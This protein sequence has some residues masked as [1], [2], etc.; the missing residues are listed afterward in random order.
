MVYRVVSLFTGI[1]GLD[2]GFGGRVVVRQESLCTSLVQTAQPPGFVALT[3]LPF[4]VVFQND[5][6]AGAK[7]VLDL[8]QPCAD[9]QVG[10]IYHLLSTNYPFPSADVVI[11]GFPCQDFSHCG[12]R[13]GFQRPTRG[14]LYRAFVEVV[15]RVQPRLFVAE[16]VYGLLTMKCSIDTIVGDFQQLGYTVS[17]Q[18]VDCSQFGVP[19]RRKRVIIMGIRPGALYDKPP[20][21]WNLI[22]KNRCHCPISVYYQHLQEPNASADAAQQLYSKG[23]RLTKGQGQTEINLRSVTPTIRAEHHG[24]IEFR[25]H[26]PSAHNPEENHL[27]QRRLTLREA[28][29]AQTF[30]PDFK[31]TPKRNMTSYKYIGNAVPPLLS[32]LIAERAYC[33]LETKLSVAHHLA[34]PIGH[35]AVVT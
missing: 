32:Y 9:Y 21:G 8:N 4:E 30:P 29:L 16:N 26:H 31:L 28:A 19:Q 22:T 3:P 24:N 17:Y 12:K 18:L 33:L 6:L 14:T 5:L 23:K 25:R 34:S 2:M 35:S 20:P 1:G 13:Q 10:D 7:E 11:G 15:K 27:P